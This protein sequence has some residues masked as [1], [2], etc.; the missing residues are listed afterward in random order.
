VGGLCI[1]FTVYG[2]LGS[3]DSWIRGVGVGAPELALEMG[4]LLSKWEGNL[5]IGRGWSGYS[6][7]N[8]GLG[9]AS[10]IGRVEEEGGYQ[11]TTL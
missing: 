11:R 2:Q 7:N 4:T 1:F 3:W 6:N 9:W 5:T 10:E 8:C